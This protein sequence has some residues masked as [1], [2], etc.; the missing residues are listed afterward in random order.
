M[1]EEKLTNAS[2]PK[3]SGT[4]NMVVEGH[5]DLLGGT[6][7]IGVSV[8]VIR[9]NNYHK[10]GLV[11]VDLIVGNRVTRF[12]VNSSGEHQYG[13]GALVERGPGDTAATLGA[14]RSLYNSGITMAEDGHLD[15][16]EV[17]SLGVQ[18]QGLLAAYYP[19]VLLKLAEKTLPK[20]ISPSLISGSSLYP[21]K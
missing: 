16:K 8:T 19:T 12:E 14:A 5:A 3:V 11:T 2:E 10:D 4:S 18:L 17:Q 15:T 21:S 1:A 7:E 9:E 13:N 6:S 20:S